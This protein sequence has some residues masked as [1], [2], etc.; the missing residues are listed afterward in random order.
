MLKYVIKYKKNDG[1]TSTDLKELY[2][3]GVNS[4]YGAEE[5]EERL[6]HML[7]AQYIKLLAVVALTKQGYRAKEEDL[8][9]NTEDSMDIMMSVCQDELKENY[10]RTLTAIE[11]IVGQGILDH[12]SDADMIKNIAS[13]LAGFKKEK[14]DL[15]KEQEEIFDN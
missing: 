6:Y 9:M 15:I 3:A 2:N 10:V 4:F 12:T 5:I 8:P 14:E 7:M 1:L 13:V 11:P